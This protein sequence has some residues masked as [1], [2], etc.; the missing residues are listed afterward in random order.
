MGERDESGC[1]YEE[2]NEL[3]VG[4]DKDAVAVELGYI[5][6]FHE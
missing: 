1:V 6:G 4:S 5:I 2:S 3:D